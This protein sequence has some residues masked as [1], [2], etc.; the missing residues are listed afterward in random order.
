MS[1]SFKR[2]WAR[3]AARLTAWLIAA[4]AAISPALATDDVF[5]VA[6]VPVRA[7]AASATEA[8]TAAQVMGR[9]RAMDI[10]L[11]R[12]TPEADWIFLPKLSAGEPA[13]ASG[14]G[15]GKTAVFVTAEQLVDLEASFEVYDEKSSPQSYRAFI[16]YRFNPEEVRA[17]LKAA[18]I[19]YSEAQTRT[20][21]VLPVLEF[22]G[23]LYLWEG[24]NPWMRAWKSRPYTYELTPLV[25]P[26][27]D[28]EDSRTVTAEGALAF[29]PEAM[30][31]LAERYGVSQ[32]IVAHARLMQT[33]DENRLN[34]ELLNAYRESGVAEVVDG[35]AAADAFADDD[36]FTDF[37]APND[38]LTGPEPSAPGGGGFGYEDALD[39]APFEVGEVVASASARGP[40]ADFPTLA[41]SLID[42]AIA[43]YASDWKQMTLIDHASEAVLPVT[44]FFDAIDDWSKIRRALVATPLVGAVRISALSPNGAEMDLRVFGDP[45][46]LQVSLENQGVTFWTETGARWFLA[47]PDVAARYRGQRF[48][49]EEKRR[50]R[51]FGEREDDRIDN[52][53]RPADAF[54]ATPAAATDPA[55]TV[56]EDG[57]VNLKLMDADRR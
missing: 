46:R 6:Q 13:T 15:A 51:F 40:R 23:G 56:D 26:R 27:G 28:I 37:D 35:F 47:R 52:F 43:K 8:K 49:R 20:A 55:D 10:L 38:E 54:D 57:F 1:I 32:I 4:V 9:R 5:V 17:L 22:N 3:R 12:L 16:T 31:T 30:L 11:R 53:G 50:R 18:K 44:A 29:E 21:L 48:L 14:D 34:V 42:A 41:E 45:A 24:N 2:D 19:P 36:A 25:A 33:E 39:E 7:E